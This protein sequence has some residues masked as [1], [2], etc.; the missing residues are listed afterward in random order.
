MFN[1]KQMN[2][3]NQR[4]K[5]NL[6]K[7]IQIQKNQYE[8][9]KIQ[10]NLYNSREYT[11]NLNKSNQTTNEEKSYRTMSIPKHFFM[12]HLQIE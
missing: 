11:Q 9:I 4:Y 10:I 8:P 6:Y 12:S 3:K 7:Q 5:L 1:P 2:T